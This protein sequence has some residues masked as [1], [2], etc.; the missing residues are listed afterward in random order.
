MKISIIR[1]EVLGIDVVRGFA[2]L[3]LL[4]KISKPDIFDERANPTGTQRDL[5]PKHARDAYEYARNTERGYWPEVFLC[6]RDPEAVKYKRTKQGRE[7]LEFNPDDIAERSDIVISRADGNHRLELADGKGKG[8][9]PIDRPVSF[10]LAMS[11]SQAEEIA[12][13]RDINDNQ[14]S[15]DTSHLDKIEIRLA[16]EDSVKSRDPALFIANRL[17]NDD[18][19]VL[20]GFVYQG[21][22]RPPGTIIP[23]RGLHTGVQYMLS[24]Q[25]KLTAL[26]GVDAQ[27]VLIKNYFSALKIWVPGAWSNP[28]DYLL[29]RGAGLWGTCFLGA[30]VIDRTLSNKNFEVLD[31]VEVLESGRKWNWTRNGDF[32]GYSGRGG[33]VKIA[34]QIIRELVDDEGINMNDLLKDILKSK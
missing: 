7:T 10:C 6:L 15:M 28:K 25:T 30:E 26:G 18:D 4:S 23:L 3:S 22:K 31:M 21:G 32:A 8:G 17:A 20:K 24:R 5:S 29:L 19:S 2:P 14:K 16:G 13:F 11:L 27:L 34:D 9:E 1:G 33:A 12:I